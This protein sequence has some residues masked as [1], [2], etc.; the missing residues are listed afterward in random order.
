MNNQ[1][2]KVC[3]LGK[4]QTKPTNRLFPDRSKNENTQRDF[5]DGIEQQAYPA[6]P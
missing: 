6:W 4:Q 3:T 2:L 5:Q 1:K